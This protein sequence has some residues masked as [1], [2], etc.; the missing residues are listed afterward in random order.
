MHILIFEADLLF[1][2]AL[3]AVFV[4]RGHQVDIF[5]G[6][7]PSE[8]DVVL[9]SPTPGRTARAV[10]HARQLAPRAHLVVVLVPRSAASERSDALRA[11]A[12]TCLDGR[13]GLAELV[14]LVEGA[15]P[16]P[17]G[18]IDS[19]SG[20]PGPVLTRREHE[21]LEALVRGKGTAELAEQ[22]GVSPATARSHVQSLLRRL[23]AHSRLEAVAIAVRTGL[24]EI[25]L[26]VEGP[27][28]HPF[29]VGG[30]HPPG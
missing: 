14:A 6:A 4:A 15:A 16:R 22:L 2:E 25:D 18:R 13:I 21:V 3:R 10:G 24:V 23:D 5:G 8:P 9:V 28:A 29:A 1:A 26:R 30:F 11:G 17:V 19:S 7:C 12:Q 27:G 20:P